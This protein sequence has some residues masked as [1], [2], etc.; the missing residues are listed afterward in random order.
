MAE[1]ISLEL[2]AKEGRADLYEAYRIIK[3]H[4]FVVEEGWEALRDNSGKEIAREDSFDEQSIFLVA[5]T[6]EN[7]QIGVVRGTALKRGF[8][9][10]ELLAHHLPHTAFKRSLDQLCELNALAILSRYRAKQYQVTEESGKGALWK[11][12]VLS[13]TRHF[14]QEGLIGAVA[15]ANGLASARLF[16]QLGFYV[17]DPPVQTGLHTKLMT[18]IGLVFGSPRHV[19]AQ[20]KCGMEYETGATTDQGKVALLRY[21]EERERE[22]LGSRPVGSES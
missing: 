20:R 3:Y 10:G 4:V 8:P 13:I 2:F 15:T 14:G 11:L 7:C 16:C 22:V 17:I 5:G 18:N 9:H 6:E 1:P 12:L 21:F 19:R